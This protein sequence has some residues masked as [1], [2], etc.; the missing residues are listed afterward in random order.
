MIQRIQTVY[1]ML[2][3]LLAVLFF[4]FPIFVVHTAE[5]TSRFIAIDNSVLFIISICI[6]TL[7]FINIFLYKN[8]LLQMKLVYLT[9]LFVAAI[10]GYACSQYFQI[11]NKDAAISFG[12]GG[13]AVILIPILQWLAYK[14]I[15]K[16]ENLV[17]SL[18]RLR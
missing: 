18:D 8:R 9:I 16:D 10:L 11:N 17:R 15:K 12:L 4:V 3:A 6:A 7:P 2:S 13:L 1:L 5:E 14:G